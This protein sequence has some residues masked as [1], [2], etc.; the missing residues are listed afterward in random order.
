LPGDVATI[1]LASLLEPHRSSER[2]SRRLKAEEKST[3]YGSGQLNADLGHANE[4]TVEVLDSLLSIF[5]RLVS[6]IT[7]SALRK[8]SGVGDFI[9]AKV[10]LEVGL[11]HG[12]GQPPNEYTG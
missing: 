12:R 3:T 9:F 1:D 7:N 10:L 6:D 4:S 2:V 8:E 11:A 5:R